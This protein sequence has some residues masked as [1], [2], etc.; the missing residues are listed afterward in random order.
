MVNM[1]GQL[2]Y[3][4]I[5]CDGESGRRLTSSAAV[6]DLETLEVGLVLDEL[7]KGLRGE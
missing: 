6:L 3:G 2:N 5:Q 7:D 1:K 4:I